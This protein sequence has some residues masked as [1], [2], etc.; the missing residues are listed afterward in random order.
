MRTGATCFCLVPLFFFFKWTV[1]HN[2]FCL[3]SVN[4][5][6][7][8]SNHIRHMACPCSPDFASTWLWAFLLLVVPGIRPHQEP[9]WVSYSHRKHWPSPEVPTIYTS[10]FGLPL[11]KGP[12]G[13]LHTST[14]SKLKPE[15]GKANHRKILLYL[16][17]FLS[18][19]LRLPG[20]ILCNLPLHVLL[21]PNFLFWAELQ[22]EVINVIAI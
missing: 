8:N 12:V 13:S 1:D 22:S 5:N 15:V 11:E 18:N 7:R 2:E 3:G 16:V 20:N 9:C 6:T 10:E 17:T 4:V 19:P 21:F 14:R